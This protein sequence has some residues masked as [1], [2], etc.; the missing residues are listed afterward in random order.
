MANSSY[1]VDDILEEIRRKKQAQG[2][3]PSYTGETPVKRPVDSSNPISVAGDFF[4]MREKGE[5]T[6]VKPKV[7]EAPT[8][9]KKHLSEPITTRTI[10]VDDTLSQYF[11]PSE[12]KNGKK[13]KEN[14]DGFASK[15]NVVPAHEKAPEPPKKPQVQEAPAPVITEVKKNDDRDYIPKDMTLHFEKQKELDERIKRDEKS[16]T[17]VHGGFADFASKEPAKPAVEKAP[18]PVEQKPAPVN[19]APVIPVVIPPEIRKT[20]S[21]PERPAPVQPPKEI[22]SETRKVEETEKPSQPKAPSDLTAS[23]NKDLYK[24]FTEKRRDK[25]E[26]FMKQVAEPTNQKIHVPAAPSD[27][28]IKNRFSEKENR[29][30]AKDLIG[31][32]HSPDTDYDPDD[33]ETIEQKD[34]ISE[35]VKNDFVF[36][37]IKTA[38]LGL[39]S[40]ISLL[41]CLAP[42]L[43]LELPEA[44]ALSKENPV[45]PAVNLGLVLLAAI[46][47]YRS[48]GNGLIGLFRLKAG[49]D[50]FASLSVIGSAVIGTMYV[51]YPETMEATGANLYFPVTILCL[52][53]INLGRTLMAARIQNNFSILISGEEKSSLMPVH[54]RELAKELTGQADEMPKFCASAKADFFT[55]FLDLSYRDDFSEGTARS[56]APIVFFGGI[57]VG[58]IA[59]L[60]TGSVTEAIIGLGAVYIVASPFAATITGNLCLYRSCKALNE[61]GSMMAGGY[62]AETFS[63]TDS[64]LLDI[65]DIFPSGSI[66]LHGIKTFAHGRIDEA[67]LDAA[68][69]ICNTKNTLE[70]IFLNVVQGDRKLLKPVDTILYEDGMGLS[71]W[72]DGKRVLIGNRELMINHNIDIPSHDYENKYV[73]SGKDIL[74]LSNSGELTAMFIISYHAEENVYKSLSAMAQRDVKLVI[75]CSDPNITAEKLAGIFDYPVDD[76]KILSSKYQQKCADLTAKREKAPAAAV[77]DGSL[78]G[79]SDLLSCCGV[80]R[81]TSFITSLIEIIGIVAGF[82]LSVV[83]LFT[84]NIADFSMVIMLVLQIFWLLAITIFS[85]LR[86]K[87]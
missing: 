28:G 66:I 50:S 53:F 31:D 58:L 83:Y 36:S 38:V 63:E 22:K 85:L 84:G 10:Q 23:S 76:L 64:V 78:N 33:F 69:V 43:G 34:I 26:E 24:E 30:I 51:L 8:F 60:L 77:Y 49:N 7:Q 18:E 62:T 27:E 56:A 57:A 44:V 42:A 68:S 71:A 82:I 86:K 19:P 32:M 55:R 48:V 14:K 5:A 59:F 1:S 67:I 6:Y 13:P 9:T 29:E 17:S 15:V 20:E 61:Q 81:Q 70:S 25:V 3:T 41:L 75:N 45:F 47:S 73:G 40:L 80:I 11:G 39:L 37:V 12:W 87:I 65:E 16:F 4:E 46:V 79:L 54:N 35:N 52:F 74:Y 72:V 2:E 21:Q